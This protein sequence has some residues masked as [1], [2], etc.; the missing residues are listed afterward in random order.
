M[1]EK[2]TAKCGYVLLPCPNNCKGNHNLFMRKDLD[3]HVAKE[4][5][6]RDYNCKHCGQGHIFD[7]ND[8]S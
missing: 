2:H 7:D 3:R 8:F 4:C 1:L 6:N 5:R